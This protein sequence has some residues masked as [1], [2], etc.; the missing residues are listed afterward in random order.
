MANGLQ[1]VPIPRQRPA[2]LVRQGG[3]E[4]QQVVDQGNQANQQ[5]AGLAQGDQGADQNPRQTF[6]TAYVTFLETRRDEI[7][8]LEGDAKV[9][10]IEGVLMQVE[11]VANE[12]AAGRVP[13]IAD[14]ETSPS[15]N[16]TTAS[17]LSSFVPPEFIPVVRGLISQLDQGVE[18]A[19]TS[20]DRVAE[21]SQHSGDDWNSRL[22]V[23]QYR[24]QSDNLAA[25]EATCNTT[26][27][28]MVLERLGISRQQVMD[29]V[30]TRIKRRL[31]RSQGRQDW[32][33]ADLS[34]VELTDENWET[35][36]RRYLD[37]QQADTA[38][39]RRLRG[40]DTTGTE[41]ENIAGIFRQNAQMEDLVDF[42]LNL[43]GVSRY[44]ISGEA[45]NVLDYIVPETGDQPTTEMIENNSRNPWATTK[46]TLRGVLDG[47]GAAMLSLYH[48][49]RGENGTHIITVQRVTEGG[50]IV[51]D[52]YG[53][54]RSTYR[55]N[56][57]GDAY[58]DPGS[59]RGGSA[60]RN[61]K[62]VN[63]LDN[64]DDADWTAAAGVDLE[65][66]ESRGDTVEL[67]DT[68]VEG[69]WRYVKVFRRAT[70]DQETATE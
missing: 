46:E 42:L 66:N 25:P 28:S 27:F 54:I 15:S 1:Q 57:T 10:R 49:G 26:S 69:M 35:E 32:R 13:T 64:A 40:Q 29:A 22:G 5:D 30:E 44:S 20:E 60:Y 55:R 43:I 41:R 12:L 47:G 68:Q 51:D 62:D 2:N 14:L 23:P 53:Q 50:I 4:D 11:W 16:G 48:K 21:G 7:A 6:L 38:R 58:A 17:E 36:I 59:T 56:R 19:T 45:D 34:E 70:G 63:D 67:E 33:T 52:P 61:V 37:A 9:Q 65:D 31:L 3:D 24:T 8:E 39:Y 18:G